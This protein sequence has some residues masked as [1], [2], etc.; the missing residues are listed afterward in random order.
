MVKIQNKLIRGLLD[1][2]SGYTLI[3]SSL[4]H[5]LHLSVR[6]VQTGELSSLFAAEGSKLRIDGVSEIII[7][8]SGLLIPH[9]VYVVE[10]I[11]ESLIFGT[12]F[13]SANN[14]LID[15][16]NRMVSLCSD[17]VRT[18]LIKAADDGPI[19]RLSKSVCIPPLSEK[20]VHVVCS[21]KSL[22]NTDV[23]VEPIPG[24][25]FIKYATARTLS[26]TDKQA[27]TVARI[28][29]CEQT[30]LTLLRGTKIGTVNAIDVA[31]SCE[32]FR[33]DPLTEPQNTVDF[34]VSNEVLEKFA[35]DYGFVINPDLLP[36]QRSELLSLLY[37]YR[38]C[39]SR[40]LKEI[41]R[42]QGYEL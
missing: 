42:Y 33:S 25:Q 29:N 10:N 20:L 21:S 15:Y 24:R 30:S 3:K 37:K 22:M 16:A 11:S 39:F 18:S 26:R 36:S 31:K 4:A 1:T 12:D 9:T 5:K 40:N 6:N 23:L 38:C 41:G 13:L 14:V 19:A 8:V 28:M 17:L 27:T 7:N 34:N 35:S 32:P 2:G